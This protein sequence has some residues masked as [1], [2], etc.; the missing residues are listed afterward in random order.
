M[1]KGAGQC[2]CCMVCMVLIFLIVLLSASIKSLEINTYGLNY[3]PIGKSV[4]E[5]VYK[6][7]IH[8]LGF[9]HSFIEFPQ[10]LQTLNFGKV[11]GSK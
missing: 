1:Q 11:D 7:G 6:S 5:K 10:Q 3:N 8:W 2:I 4:E 9:A